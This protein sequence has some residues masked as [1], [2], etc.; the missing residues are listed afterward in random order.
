MKAM[1]INKLKN[2]QMFDKNIYNFNVKCK[3]KWVNILK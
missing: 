2:Y 1:W 3:I